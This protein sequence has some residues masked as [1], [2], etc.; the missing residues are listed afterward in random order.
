MSGAASTYNIIPRQP[1]SLNGLL[2]DFITRNK[3]EE[4]TAVVD[5]AEVESE[6]ESISPEMTELALESTE[7]VSTDVEAQKAEED[8][9]ELTETQKLLKKVKQA[10]TAGGE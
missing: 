1:T 3:S 8:E 6:V 9:E 10:G 2:P 5:T 4:D 7:T